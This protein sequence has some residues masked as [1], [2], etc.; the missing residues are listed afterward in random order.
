MSKYRVSTFQI[1][2]SKVLEEEKKFEAITKTGPVHKQFVSEPIKRYEPVKKKQ[3]RSAP[4]KEAHKNKLPNEDSGED[5]DIFDDPPIMMKRVERFLSIVDL[6][7]DV[8]YATQQVFAQRHS[9][10]AEEDENDEDEQNGQVTA[11]T[12]V[13]AV[14][15]FQKCN[16]FSYLQEGYGLSQEQKAK[17]IAN[18]IENFDMDYYL[19][20]FR[21][22]NAALIKLQKK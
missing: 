7:Q 9:V 8:I 18:I 20:E 6:P 12:S 22:K 2:P 15:S 16:K 11:K 21:E 5:S 13:L 3:R 10:I 14:K 4:K 17:I 19:N 1:F